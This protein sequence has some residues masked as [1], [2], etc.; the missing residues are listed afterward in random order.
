VSI[1]PYIKLSGRLLIRNIKRKGNKTMVFT[2]KKPSEVTV[3]LSSKVETV[4]PTMA[5]EMLSKNT[6]NRN[7]KSGI[8]KY[9]QAEIE[10]GNWDVNGESIKIATDGTLLDGQHRLEA[11]SRS[12]VAVD[13]FVVR[14][15]NKDVFTTIDAGKSRN[16]GDYLKIAGHDGNTTTLAAAGRISMFFGEDGVFRV[17]G[18]GTAGKQGNRVSPEDMVVYVEKHPGLAESIAKIQKSVGKILPTSIAIGCHY[19]F[20]I[21]DMEKADDFFHLLC[22]GES[23]KVGNPVLAL[24]NR[25]ISLRGD[26]RAGEGHR[27]MLVYYVVH[28]WNAYMSGRELKEVKYQTDYEIKIDGFKDSVLSNWK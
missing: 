9:Y 12:G 23:L 5:R 4:T 3:P 6:N 25:L 27:R 22:T 28:A 1:Y 8:V 21:I 7:M 13:T 24:R 15:L 2:N 14:G 17:G 19:I 10:N 20:S 18:H 11:I 26:G 16:H